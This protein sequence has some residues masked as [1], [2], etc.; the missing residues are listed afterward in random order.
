MGASVTGAAES[1]P[2]QG[3]ATSGRH[4]CDIDLRRLTR[5]RWRLEVESGHPNAGWPLGQEN[6]GGLVPAVCR[7]LIPCKGLAFGDPCDVFI[8]RPGGQRAKPTGVP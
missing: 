2:P 1:S 6:G 8:G 7:N 5:R 4:I 3:S